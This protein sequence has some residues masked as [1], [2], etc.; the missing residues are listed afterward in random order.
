MPN[1]DTLLEGAVINKIKSLYFQNFDCTNLLDRIDFS[2]AEKNDTLGLFNAILD[3]QYYLWAE[4]KRN[5]KTSIE[6]MFTQL[7]LTIGISDKLKN[8]IPP[9]FLGVFNDETISFISYENI[10]FIFSINDFDWTKVKTPSNHKSAEFKKAKNLLEEYISSDKRTDFHFRNSDTGELIDSESKELT[11]FIRRNF[12][13]KLKSAELGIEINKNNFVSVYTRWLKEVKDTISVDWSI[14]KAKGILDTDFYLADLLSK[15][16]EA[17]KD[18]L[19]VTLHNDHYCFN[20]QKTELGEQSFTAYFKDKGKTHSSFWMRYKRPPEASRCTYIL[21][22]RDLLVPQ[23][24]REI[25]GAYFTSQIWVEKSQE[26]LASVLGENWQDE[27][28]IWDC[29]AG[30]G[31]MENGLTNK[32]RV[33]ASTIDQA[34]VDV[35]K[36]R[37]RN[38]ANLLESHVFQMD[39]LNDEFADKCP[40]DLLGILKDPEKRKKL[41]IYINPPYAE[42]TSLKTINSDVK[43]HKGGLS[44]TAVYQKYEKILGRGV[45]ELYIQ[46]FV[47][48]YSEISDCIIGAFST[49]KLLQSQNFVDFRT[50]FKATL[51]KAF[52]VPANTFDNVTGKFPI[53]FLIWNTNEKQEF[54]EGYIDVYNAKNLKVGTKKIQSVQKNG[55]ILNWMQ[56]YYDKKSNRL[57]YMVRGASDFQN[58]RIVFISIKPSD[59]VIKHS[60]THNVTAYNLIE[61]S[62]FFSVRHCIPMNWLNNRDQFLIPNEKWN[63]DNNFQTNCFAYLLFH[64][65]NMIQSEHGINHWIPFTEQEVDAKSNFQSNFMTDYIK[66]NKLVFS[67]EA[68]A[69]FNAGREL[70]KY[71]HSKPNANPNAS[72]YDI[73][74]CFQGKDKKGDMNKKST[75]EHYNTLLASLKEAMS[76]LESHIVPKIYEYGFLL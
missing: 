42:A 35:M 59:A 15:N 45:N 1:D 31:N 26:Y 44:D 22:H 54:K 41:I 49:L 12:K 27:Y 53:G 60:Q 73:R 9:M 75:D 69:V 71:Y 10:Q 24:I 39:F 64:Q 34:D 14:A 2:V 46:F 33:W 67:E 13:T 65:Q 30:T 29:C 4:A 72:Y 32:Y 21:E 11:K 63:T 68:Q 58:N 36:D 6:D 56:R 61:N 28:Y 66:N 52:V 47:R 76:V 18:D 16:N 20:R 23:D 3:R 48:I 62:I 7:V 50:F 51:K 55:V 70:W 43:K 25:K 40:Q 74:L 38:G 57:A 8:V 37:I 19:F 17:I 5:N